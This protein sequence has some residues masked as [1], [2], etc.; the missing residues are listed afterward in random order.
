MRYSC[1]FTD[2]NEKLPL[3]IFVST[4]SL[5]PPS[6]I[7]QASV[8]SREWRR[9]ILSSPSLHRE[10]DLT[11]MSSF[12][13]L[14][15]IVKHFNRISTLSH[16]R[17]I[18][19][20]LHM[21]PFFL[22]FEKYLYQEFK[23]F[24]ALDLLLENLRQSK[25][26]VKEL[27]FELND[28]HHVN[29]THTNEMVRFLTQLLGRLSDFKS[30]HSISIS[31]PL[32]F[33]LKCGN[34]T[35]NS[36]IMVKSKSYDSGCESPIMIVGFLKAAKVLSGNSIREFKIEAKDKFFQEGSE[37]LLMNE[38]QMS[39]STMKRL[40]IAQLPSIDPRRLWDFVL[41]FPNL[42]YLKLF[43]NEP[44]LED[45]EPRMLEVPEGTP[46]CVNLRELDL[47][48][49]AR[50]DWKSF[51]KWIGGKL[52]IL[53]LGLQT[54]DGNEDL[55]PSNSY[56]LLLVDSQ[57]TLKKLK[58][59]QRRFQPYGGYFLEPNHPSRNLA[60]QPNPFSNLSLPKLETVEIN[61][62]EGSIFSFV[63]APKLQDLTIRLGS[64][65][66]QPTLES[67]IEILREFSSN[68]LRLDISFGT[69][70][71]VST[72]GPLT[73]PVLEHLRFEYGSNFKFFRI[74]SRNFYPRLY[75]MAYPYEFDFDCRGISELFKANSP[76]RQQ[77]D[78]Y[79]LKESTPKSRV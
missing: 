11:S 13:D 32:S 66:G 38:L 37:I 9:D 18:K 35:S 7:A 36:V 61:N 22:E 23:R 52:E 39:A 3:E 63:H 50:L 42:E 4:L 75:S 2:P 45:E 55:L 77:L 25:E 69:G 26:T 67:L 44:D 46:S 27:N 31:A 47:R 71:F 20:S 17:V 78:R 29:R 10:I 72:Q 79:L 34:D 6:S 21:T 48:V 62:V 30:F 15:L 74:M 40:D 73:F 43:I 28:V 16:N 64:Y 60:P 54:R 5:L 1:S 59:H 51:S 12:Q 41:V 70:V 19:V 58:L 8:T 33:D 57:Q 65:E 53:R 68:L 49:G 76:N 24:V 56:G 14:S